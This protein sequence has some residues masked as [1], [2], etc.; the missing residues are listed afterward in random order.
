MSPE[1]GD[2]SNARRQN[3]GP[4]HE[5][6][7]KGG[8]FDR[9]GLGGLDVAATT[10]ALANADAYLFGYT[11][12]AAQTGF[13]A[14]IVNGSTTVNADTTGW[15]DFSGHHLASNPDY[16]VGNCSIVSCGGAAA[17]NDFFTFNL[18]G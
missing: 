17:Y 16:I 3:K 15:Y 12:G 5:H 4:K 7:H 11:Y 8:G 13:D 6:E 14:L 9:R 1:G 18:S 10:P 2:G